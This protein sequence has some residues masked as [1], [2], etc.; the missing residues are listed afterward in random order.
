MPERRAAVAAAVEAIRAIETRDGVTRESPEDI[1]AVLDGLAGRRDLFG[2]DE[3]PDPD[4]GGR[5]RLYLLHED[6][7]GRFPLYLTCSRPGGSVPPH[8]HTTW[9]VVSGL[10]GEEENAP[11][12]RTD[13]GDGPGAASL[14]E[15]QRITVPPGGHL[16]LMP[17]DIHS[18][19]T[20]GRVPRRHFHMYGLSLERLP[21][22]LVYDVAAGQCRHMEAN[23]KIVR[24]AHA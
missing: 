15:C 19:S 7:G 10:S 17:D 13:P 24:V 6:P 18:V 1:A 8:N 9:A 22:R 20:P 5:A 3:F 16:A 21:A 12:E 23:P 2:T 11:W 14:R 4:L